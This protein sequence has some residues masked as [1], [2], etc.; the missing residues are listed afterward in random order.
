MGRDFVLVS[1]Q[2]E[3]NRTDLETEFR[4]FNL[5]LTMHDN[6]LRMQAF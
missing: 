2:R 4:T 5:K 3:L 1:S 6:S